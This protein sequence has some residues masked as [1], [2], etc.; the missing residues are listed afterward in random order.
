MKGGNDVAKRRVFVLLL[1]AYHNFN[2]KPFE[3]YQ[4]LVIKVQA[5][6][7]ACHP[8]GVMAKSKYSTFSVS[9][10]DLEVCLMCIFLPFFGDRYQ[11]AGLHQDTRKSLNMPRFLCD[12]S[13]RGFRG[14]RLMLLLICME[15]A[16]GFSGISIWDGRKEREDNVV[17]STS[18]T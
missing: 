5:T 4:P 13:G 8:H 2:Y 18:V 9:T 10:W 3:K 12:H 6:E 11:L 17:F 1:H 14:I 15:T 16:S 7:R